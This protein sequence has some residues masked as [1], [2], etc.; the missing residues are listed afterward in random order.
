MGLN[1]TAHM[2]LTTHST[3]GAGEVRRGAVESPARAMISDIARTKCANCRT[4]APRKCPTGL[5]PGQRHV[6]CLG[7]AA[8]RPGI[9]PGPTRTG[10]HLPHT[11]PRAAPAAATPAPPPRGVPFQQRKSNEPL[12]RIEFTAG[13]VVLGLVIAGCGGGSD[14]AADAQ[15]TAA[16][17]SSA[18]EL[19]PALERDE[20]VARFKNVLE[21]LR[22]LPQLA[23]LFDLYQVP[24]PIAMGD[25]EQGAGLIALLQAVKITQ[26]GGTV[27]LPTVTRAASSTPARARTWRRAPSTSRTCP[28]GR[29]RRRRR[30]R[31]STRTGAPA[32]LTGRRP[33]R[34]PRRRPRAA[35]GPRSS[36]RPA[37]TPSPPPPRPARR[38]TTRRGAPASPT[39]PR[40]AR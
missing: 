11:S 1:L 16:V 21:Q 35:P 7:D 25:D 24:D 38:S 40:R 29:R 6:P 18:K 33:G 32:S 10:D 14:P 13:V 5:E 3:T 37:P 30:A 8:A 9:S 23:P 2:G 27:T 15:L 31:T 26:D 4:S 17:R 20:A 19:E 39:A 22:A 34:S 36:R 12:L 28:A